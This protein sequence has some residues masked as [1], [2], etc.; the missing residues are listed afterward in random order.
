MIERIRKRYSEFN[1]LRKLS[2]EFEEGME[3][4]RMTSKGEGEFR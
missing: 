4:S 3:M 2:N 1:G